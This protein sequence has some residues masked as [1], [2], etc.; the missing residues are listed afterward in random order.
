MLLKAQPRARGATM[1]RTR[2][3]WLRQQAQR[4]RRLADR[5]T[6]WEVS[7]RLLD[8]AERFEEQAAAEDAQEPKD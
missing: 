7:E 8:L 2:A 1:T 5:I 6:D 4:C 3:E